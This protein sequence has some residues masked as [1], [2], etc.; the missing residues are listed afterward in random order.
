MVL[1]AIGNGEVLLWLVELFFLVVWFWLLISIFGDLFRDRSVSGGAKALWVLFV[2]IVPLVGILVYLIVRGGGMADRTA[3]SMQEA[4]KQ[5]DDY[6]RQ[7]AGAGA[8]PTDQIA[9][10]K[11]LLDAGTIDQNEFD[12]LK[13]KALG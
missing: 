6:V 10:A 2:L 5:F 8:T 4:Q 3:Q 13:A 11:A 7:T 1:S 9:S 12:R